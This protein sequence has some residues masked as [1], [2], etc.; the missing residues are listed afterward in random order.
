MRKLHSF[1]EFVKEKFEDRLFNAIQNYV[2]CNFSKLNLESNRVDRIDEVEVYDTDIKS[3]RVCDDKNWAI[4]FDIIVTAT[5]LL[6]GHKH[7]QGQDDYCERWFMFSCMGDLNK[8]LKDFNIISLSEYKSKNS[9]AAPMTD[10][11]IPY[12]KNDEYE[13]YASTILK[14]LYP[15]AL[16]NT[17]KIDP[18]ELVKRIGLNVLIRSISADGTVFGQLFFRGSE[19]ELYE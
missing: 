9:Y 6:K 8:K 7:S 10:S 19:A 4:K 14:K 12:I 1:K 2:D 15:E 16:Q 3:V 11:L 5:L 18:E 17:I 13:K